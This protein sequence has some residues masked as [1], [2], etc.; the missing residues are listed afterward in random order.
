[1]MESLVHNDFERTSKEVT[2]L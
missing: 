1:M 2:M